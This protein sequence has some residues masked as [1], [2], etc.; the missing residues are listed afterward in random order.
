MEQ[1]NEFNVVEEEI[2]EATENNYF[3]S[4]LKAAFKK[5]TRQKR[6]REA[7]EQLTCDGWQTF[8]FV[9]E[10]LEKRY[11][12]KEFELLGCVWFVENIINYFLKPFEIITKHRAP[13]SNL[14]EHSSNKSYVCPITRL[15]DRR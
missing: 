11:S 12:L 14:R 15:T 13:L 2:S 4:N 1:E 3:N 7:F 5:E 10:S 9:S 8:W 6:L